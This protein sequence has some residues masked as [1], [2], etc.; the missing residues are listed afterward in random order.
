MINDKSKLKS[1]LEV[2]KSYFILLSLKV[3][4]YEKLINGISMLKSVL[5]VSYYTIIINLIFLIV[6]VRSDA[7]S[8][9]FYA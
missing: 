3:C 8:D 9:L 4:N 1:I 7:I 5:A 2:L 6:H